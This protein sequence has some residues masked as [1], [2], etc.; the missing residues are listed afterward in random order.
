MTYYHCLAADPGTRAPVRC[1]LRAHFRADCIEEKLWVWVTGFLLSPETLEQ[2]LADCQADLERNAAPRRRRLIVVDDLLADNHAQMGRLLDLYLFGDFPKE[3]LAER[4]TRLQATIAAL[5][6]ER[7]NLIAS[8]EKDIFP[9]S[10]SRPSRNS[11][12]KPCAGWNWLVMISKRGG[13]YCAPWP[14]P[15]C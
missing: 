5:E 1:D 11:R 4:K 9:R 12:T 10:A 3:V 8:L 15:A 6:K 14:L 2:G 7:G 13:R